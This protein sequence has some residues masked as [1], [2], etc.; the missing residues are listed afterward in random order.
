MW[1]LL[2]QQRRSHARLCMPSPPFCSPLLPLAWVVRHLCGASLFVPRSFRDGS[3]AIPLGAFPFGRFAPTCDLKSGATSQASL[4]GRHIHLPAKPAKLGPAR[5]DGLLR[6]RFTASSC[7]SCAAVF[8]PQCR[9]G[10]A[11]LIKRG[12]RCSLTRPHVELIRANLQKF[13]F[14]ASGRVC[15]GLLPHRALD[16]RRRGRKRESEALQMGLT[17]DLLANIGAECA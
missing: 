11:R 8:G 3:W 9:C 4:T 6:S 5:R 16:R 12:R 14:G 1:W 7:F 13:R 15:A 2:L 17:S 10:I